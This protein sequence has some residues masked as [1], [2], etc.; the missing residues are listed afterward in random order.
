MQ[1]K[2]SI[3]DIDIREKKVFVRVDFNVPLDENQQ[4]TEDTRIREALPTIQYALEQQAIVI[5]ASHLGRPKGERKPEFS[6]APVAKRLS[7]LLGTQV[8]F[9]DDCIGDAVKQALSDAKP[10]DV[11]LLENL[12]FY[13]GEEKND[14][15]FAKK[16]AEGCD[17]AVNDAFGTAHRAHAS[18]VGVAQYLSPSVAG[19]LMEKEIEYFG[20]VID[21]PERP[22]VAILG[23]AK[24]SGK[25][26]VITNLMKKVDKLII[27]GGMMFTF[28]KAQGLNVGSSLVEEDLVDTAK[29]ILQ[30]ADKAGLE[31]LLPVDCLIADKFDATANT[32]LVSVDAIPEGWMGL[33]IGYESSKLFV[34][35]VK[36]VKTIVWNGPMGVFEM[37]A[38]SKGTVDLAQAV[39]NS[40]ATSIIGGGDTISAI[41]KAGVAEKISFIST[42]GGASLELL[43][44]KELPGIAVLTNKRA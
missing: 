30:Q 16:L 28:L 17:I 42:G 44:G 14:P 29:D 4:V 24:V 19:F 6:L 27:G 9:L 8:Q 43:E 7:E 33:D 37:D 20:K 26:Q 3:R 36:G 40:G 32:Q 5:L 10:G 21:N 39:A 31:L 25:L 22:L 38:F 2:L 23:G 35:A 11:I 34:N 12:R 15:E 1:K 18:N 13:K 41:Q